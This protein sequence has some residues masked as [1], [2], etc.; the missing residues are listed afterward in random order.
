MD[1]KVLGSTRFDYILSHNHENDSSYHI[2]KY[3]IIDKLVKE[4]VKKAE[5][6]VNTCKKQHIQQRKVSHSKPPH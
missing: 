1:L 3:R 4:Y 5:I 2:E 6:G